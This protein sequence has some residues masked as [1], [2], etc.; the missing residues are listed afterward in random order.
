MAVLTATVNEVCERDRPRTLAPRWGFFR[1][2]LLFYLQ[3]TGRRSI[4]KAAWC[5]EPRKRRR[6]VIFE[7]EGQESRNRDREEVTPSLLSAGLQ[8]LTHFSEAAHLETKP[9]SAFPLPWQDTR[10]SSPHLLR[11]EV[12]LE[13]QVMDTTSTHGYYRY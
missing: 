7:P 1:L 10:V 12:L 11:G 8:Q 4:L 9:N 2:L 5:L 3:S 6:L 13:P